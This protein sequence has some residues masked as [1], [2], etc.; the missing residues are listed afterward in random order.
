MPETRD[1]QPQPGPWRIEYEEPY[2]PTLLDAKG[3]PVHGI[4]LDEDDAD[5]PGG[6]L[7]DT[8]RANSKLAAAGPQMA[9]A[10]QHVLR[11]LS[12]EETSGPSPTRTS[13]AFSPGALL[14][15][16]ESAKECRKAVQE[17]LT[18]AGLA[19]P[20]AYAPE[21]PQVAAVR[22]SLMEA[23]GVDSAAWEELHR[24]YCAET[25]SGMVAKYKQFLQTDPAA[26]ERLEEM[27]EAVRYQ[28]R[29][30]TN[31]AAFK[32]HI[33]AFFQALTELAI[34]AILEGKHG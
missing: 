16:I 2:C 20:K 12:E 26:K 15:L 14:A 34:P 24:K 19:P 4:K 29:K 23:V 8:I 21:D 30:E 7:N 33:E 3:D 22:K 27:V 31:T 1:H 25:V 9:A 6:D 5:Y 18:E 28:L 10:L 11:Y 17:A 32:P 13:Q